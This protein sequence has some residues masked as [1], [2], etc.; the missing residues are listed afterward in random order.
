MLVDPSDAQARLHFAEQVLGQY[1]HAD[2]SRTLH[3]AG[4]G[5][6]G[7]R[8]STVAERAR[9][10]A[11]LAEKLATSAELR[12]AHIRAEAASL[13]RRRS[14]AQHRRPET[15]QLRV[16][17]VANIRSP[18]I[19][20][21]QMLLMLPSQ[22]MLR[23]ASW[24]NAASVASLAVVQTSIACQREDMAAL[25]CRETLHVDLT[26]LRSI[27]ELQK[28]AALRLLFFAEH[29]AAAEQHSRKREAAAGLQHSVAVLHGIAYSWGA[30][31][32]GQLGR[33]SPAERFHSVPT[34]ILLPSQVVMVA[35][36]GDHSLLVTESGAVWAFGRN[37]E[38]QLGTGNH[39]DAARPTAM[40]VPPATQAA[41]GA[42][43]S[44]VLAADGA[45]WSCGRGKEGQ[46][47]LCSKQAPERSL[48]PVQAA[49]LPKSVS[50]V[51][52]GADHSVVLDDI[53]RVFSFGENSKGQLGLG[54]CGNQFGPALML[55]PRGF[56]AIS[57]DCGGTHTLVVGDTGRILGCGSNDQGQLGL[58]PPE[59]R[60]VP[61]P[62]TWSEV[63]EPDS[64]RC[65]SCGFDNSAVLTRFGTVWVLGGKGS[66][67]SETPAPWRIRGSL[68]RMRINDVAAGGGHALCLAGQA[69]YILPLGGSMQHAEFPDNSTH[70]TPHQILPSPIADRSRSPNMECVRSRSV[71]PNRLKPSRLTR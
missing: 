68:E 21:G 23:V 14:S 51:A 26:R 8:S 47:G 34:Q 40:P 18:D 39:R 55:L 61:V 37:S 3:A 52:C 48:W 2:I 70:A 64:G 42:D 10:Q 28:V 31:S 9:L 7:S 25:V 58:G 29:Q 30:A 36:G 59:E 44:I 46:L 12:A 35:C 38:G 50:Q 27:P 66:V 22:L 13:G 1:S 60:L 56:L 24:L 45:V 54:H 69:V 20:S 43:H 4:R 65:V 49:G 32:S 5:Y 53:G 17:V 19:L 41:C 63:G 16:S 11:A 67:H 57:A 71:T 6:K 15:P 62:I 33:G